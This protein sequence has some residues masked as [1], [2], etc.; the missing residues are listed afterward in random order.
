MYLNIHFVSQF[1]YSCL[2]LCL[3]IWGDE[4]MDLEFQS[5]TKTVP[6]KQITGIKY[7][8]IKNRIVI[9]TIQYSHS[10]PMGAHYLTGS[11][12]L[13]IT[14]LEKQVALE[15]YHHLRAVLPPE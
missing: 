14:T 11:G 7:D 4:K 3:V 9:S 6:I 5:K 10:V 15:L 13:T 8:P 2:K 1:Q 12:Q